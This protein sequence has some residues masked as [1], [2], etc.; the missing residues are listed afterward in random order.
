MFQPSSFL[1]EFLNTFVLNFFNY[2]KTYI[3]ISIIFVITLGI[4][5]YSL[6]KR[7]TLSRF[8]SRELSFKVYAEI[9]AEKMI[10]FYTILLFIFISAK[11]KGFELAEH[12]NSFTQTTNILSLLIM[13]FPVYCILAALMNLV[14]IY[15]FI[16]NGST[17][18][19]SIIKK[20]DLKYSLFLSSI[21]P[22]IYI[23]FTL[24]TPGGLKLF[25]DLFKIHFKIQ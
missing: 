10:L 16:P 1:K 11:L 2:F 13:V 7:Y 22:L 21:L 15:A 24:I 20:G 19:M 4:K 6:K 25:L 23:I 14:L 12:V 17:K 3:E 18:K 5:K 8:N 9:I